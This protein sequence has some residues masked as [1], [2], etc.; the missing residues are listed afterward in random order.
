MLRVTVTNDERSRKAK[1][2]GRI[3]GQSVEELRRICDELLAD[4]GE[5]QMILDLGDVSFVD[6]DGIELLRRLA[7]R[8]VVLA[9]RSPFLAELL[10]EV[11]P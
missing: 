6:A 11:A 4:F 9:N 5:A 8:D 10:K 2:E 1:I 7:C 3:A